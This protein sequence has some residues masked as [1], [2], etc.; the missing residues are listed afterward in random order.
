[1]TEEKTL[2]L[3]LEALQLV[4]IEF[5]CNGAHHAKKDRHDWLES[6]P[7]VERYQ[8]AITA[9]KEALAK[10]QERYFCS[11]CG[12]RLSKDINDVHSC[13]PPRD[14]HGEPVNL[15]LRTFDD[16]GNKIK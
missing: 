3:A 8:T 2:K 14:I 7:I 11:R 6:C 5:V 10:P 4:S 9:I 15:P 12:K 1:M 13:T 16:Y